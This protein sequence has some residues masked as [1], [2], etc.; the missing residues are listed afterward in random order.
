MDDWDSVTKIGSKSRGGATSRETVVRGK[1]AL[2]A[3]QR[4]GAV[5]GTEKKFGA[6]NSVCLLVTHPLSLTITNPRSLGLQ[7]RCR[8]PASHEGRSQR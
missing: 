6:G 4:S 2:N 5:V 7:T 1:A 3:A 8:R